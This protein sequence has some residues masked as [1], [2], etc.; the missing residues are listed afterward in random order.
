MSPDLLRYRA[1]PR[2]LRRLRRDGLAAGS[3]RAV[4]GPASGPK[5][6]VLAGLDRALLDSGLL[7]PCPRSGRRTLLAG[8]SAGAWRMLA[9][10]CRDPQR[11]HRRLLE[12]Y[13]EQVFS[14]RDTPRTVSLAYRAL[15]AEL[16]TD[17]AHI[18]DHPR[19]DLAI[20]T[21]RARLGASRAALI[22]SILAAASVGLCAGAARS[23]SRRAT[24]S[25]HGRDGPRGSAAGGSSRGASGL[26]FERVLFHSRPARFRQPFDGRLVTLDRHN[27]LAAARASGSVPIYLEAIRDI[28]GAPPG[29][30]VDGGLTDYHL[31]Q[32]YAEADSGIVLLPHFRQRIV[33][34][35]LDRWRPAPSPSTATT[36]DLLQLYPSPELESRLA[37]GQ[38]PDRGDFK[39]FMANP[40]ERI[41]RW[42]A[43]VTASEALGEQFLADLESGRLPDR[44][45]PI[46]SPP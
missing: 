1:G 35:W 16:L 38:L 4:F 42:R 39:R 2:A 5:W 20:H 19:F 37:G 24:G 22:A 44:V 3:I 34:C 26:L 11:A 27:L 33:P 45:R 30:Y 6:L 10:A 9:F 12:R 21:A 23:L 32:T 15:L 14:P 31:N 17:D 7:Q 40:G 8:S 43:A 25:W 36:S 46:A 18:L 13:V 41:R 28:P 29:G